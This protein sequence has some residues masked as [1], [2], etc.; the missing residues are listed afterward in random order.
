MMPNAS[1]NSTSLLELERLPS[2]SLRRILAA[3]GPPARHEKAAQAQFGARQHHVRIAHRRR[4][5]P[6]VAAQQIACAAAAAAFQRHGRGGVAAHIGA[7][8]LFR[9]AHADQD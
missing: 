1:R 3:V 9:H 5:K 7:A 4:E 2:L 8:L 6:F